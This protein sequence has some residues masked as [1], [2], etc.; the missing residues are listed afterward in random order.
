MRGDVYYSIGN[1][2]LALQDYL[3]AVSNKVYKIESFEKA[4]RIETLTDKQKLQLHN[5]QI[6]AQ[7]Q[8]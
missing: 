4:L 5:F 8:L 7:K 2:Q 1:N 6:M 3:A